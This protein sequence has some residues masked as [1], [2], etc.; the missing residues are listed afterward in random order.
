VGEGDV[1]VV[2][3]VVVVVV[4]EAVVVVVG[5][6]VVVPERVLVFCWRGLCVDSPHSQPKI[7]WS[8]L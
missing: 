5:L 2:V 6:G 8:W 1:V 7:W 4:G 3:L